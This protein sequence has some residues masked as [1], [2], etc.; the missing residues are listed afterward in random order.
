MKVVN[1]LAVR[2]IFLFVLFLG[3]ASEVSAAPE[4]RILSECDASANVRANISKDA[5]LQIHFAIAGAPTCY[6]VTATVEGKQVRGYILDAGLDA[7]VAFEK[8][9][10][11]VSREALEAQL[12]L[13]QPPAKL[14][15][16]GVKAPDEKKPVAAEKPVEAQKPISVTPKAKAPA[17]QPL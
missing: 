9:R 10:M 17:E 6:S 5:Q 13:P 1:L 4:Y 2:M 3:I 8:S 12:A 16:P 14:A 15:D 11:K 7:I